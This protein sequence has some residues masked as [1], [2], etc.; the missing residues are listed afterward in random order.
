MGLGDQITMSFTS[1]FSGEDTEAHGVQSLV[2]PEPQQA[3]A[4]DRPRGLLPLLARSYLLCNAVSQM[5]A[6]S[7]RARLAHDLV[8]KICCG[9]LP[10]AY[11]TASLLLTTHPSSPP[12]KGTADRCHLPPPGQHLVAGRGEEAGSWVPFPGREKLPLLTLCWAL[13]LQLQELHAGPE[14]GSSL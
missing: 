6:A 3:G 7:S 2:P 11:P 14:G 10:A 9:R 5:R 12:P 8:Y 4:W 1:L 13:L